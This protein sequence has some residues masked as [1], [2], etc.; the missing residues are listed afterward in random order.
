MELKAD[1]SPPS[2]ARVKNEQS[3][4]SAPPVSLQG[5]GMI[6]LPLRRVSQGALRQGAQED[7]WDHEVG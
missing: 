3:S 5:K 1:H 4:N 2:S 7:I 6:I